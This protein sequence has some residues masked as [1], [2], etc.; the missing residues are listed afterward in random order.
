MILSFTSGGSF[1]SRFD[2]N[3]MLR[4]TPQHIFT[5]ANIDKLIIY[6]DAVNTRMLVFLRKPFALQHAID[7]VLIPR[8]TS[9]KN[10][11]RSL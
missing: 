11:P 5:L 2:P 4:Q 7:V 10:L 1:A 3:P 9:H 8:T 6:A